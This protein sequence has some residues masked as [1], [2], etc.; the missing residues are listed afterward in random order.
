MQKQNNCSITASS[1]VQMGGLITMMQERQKFSIKI[2]ALYLKSRCCSAWQ[3]IFPSTGDWRGK[4][5]LERDTLRNSTHYRYLTYTQS[6]SRNQN[7]QQTLGK[8]AELE[9][10]R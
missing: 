8:A 9:S 4:A 3:S 5:A 7:I 6:T 2:P 10:V 1:S